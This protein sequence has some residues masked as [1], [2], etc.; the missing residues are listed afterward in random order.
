M[1]LEIED[2][3]LMPKEKGFS[4]AFTL[5]MRFTVSSNYTAFQKL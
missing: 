1:L 2:G 5:K 4:L 3:G